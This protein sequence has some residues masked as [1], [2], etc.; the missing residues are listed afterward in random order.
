[1]A[2]NTT[3]DR[4]LAKLR[5]ESTQPGYAGAYNQQQYKYPDPTQQHIVNAS[6]YATANNSGGTGA[7]TI[8]PPGG[9]GGGS[10]LGLSTDALAKLGL[11]D[12]GAPGLDSGGFGSSAQTDPLSGFA[13]RYTPGMLQAGTLY[14]HPEILSAD[15]LKSMGYNSGTLANLFSPMADAGYA[16]DLIMNGSGHGR[17]NGTDNATIN[18]VAGLLQNMATPGGRTIDTDYAMRH[19]LG[20]DAASPLGSYLGLVDPALGGTGGQATGV[21]ST[22]TPQ[23]QIDAYGQ[24]LGAAIQGMNPYYQR[25][26]SNFINTAESGYQG[27]LSHGQKISD[28]GAYLR[29]TPL[30]Q[31]AGM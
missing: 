22:L 23:Q 21:A 3:L 13:A 24:L 30:A 28:Y 16:L 6:Q 27:A 8:A 5:K 20:A 2:T 7:R 10:D 29:G 18:W 14:S 1:M 9:G 25:A 31:W 26:M 17:A 19:I 12:H 15:V 11:T 4:Y